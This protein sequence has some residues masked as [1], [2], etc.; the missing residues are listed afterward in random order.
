MSSMI[1][2][3]FYFVADAYFQRFT[4]PYLM[5]N[6]G[7]GHNRPCFYAYQDKATGLYWMIPISSKVSK[8]R[9]IE[10]SK[11][12]RYG[13]CNTI[14]FGKV[15]GR[16]RA[17]LIQNMFPV[18]AQYIDSQYIDSHSGVPVRVANALSD[19]ITRNAKSV[20]A[21]QRHGG[22]PIFPNVLE[23]ERQ[24]LSK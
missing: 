6:K 1:A 4:D 15:L 11:I 10:A 3:V 13:Y 9:G 20:L 17:F 23:I 19:Q 5:P 7:V 12:K 24:L 14:V 2:G 22:R 8:Y 18:T 21:R 16:E